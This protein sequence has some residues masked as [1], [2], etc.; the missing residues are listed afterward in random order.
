MTKTFSVN[1]ICAAKNDGWNLVKE[2]II[3]GKVRSVVMEKEGNAF[4]W[5][6]EDQKIKQEHYK[7]LTNTEKRLYRDFQKR[8]ARGLD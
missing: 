8:Y 3:A 2:N 7:K 1:E 5:L 6:E 4:E